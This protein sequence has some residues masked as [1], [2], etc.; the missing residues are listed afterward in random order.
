MTDYLGDPSRLAKQIAQRERY[1]ADLSGW[2]QRLSDAD[3]ANLTFMLQDHPTL[4]PD[5]A[6]ALGSSQMV[7]Y[8]NPMLNE[9]ADLDFRKQDSFDPMSPLR[10]AIRGAATVAESWWEHGAPSI[11]RTLTRT[12]QGENPITAWRLGNTSYLQEITKQASLGNP[13]DI[14]SGFFPQSTPTHKREGYLD[15]FKTAYE[16]TQDYNASMAT[17]NEAM[18]EKYGTVLTEDVHDIAEST[19]VNK[20]HDGQVYSVPFSPGRALAIQFARPDTLPFEIMSTAVDFNSRL[21]LDP[22]NPVFYEV[23]MWAINRR[24]LTADLDDL[25]TAEKARILEEE[26]GVA[27]VLDS[28]KR[29]GILASTDAQS[30]RIREVYDVADEPR[31][32]TMIDER[33]DDAYDRLTDAAKS[34]PDGVYSSVSVDDFDTLDDPQLVDAFGQIAGE[35]NPYDVGLTNQQMHDLVEEAGGRQAF[36]DYVFEHEYAHQVSQEDIMR[37]LDENNE[38]AIRSRIVSTQ[39]ERAEKWRALRERRNKIVSE[40][41]QKLGTDD[42]LDVKAIEDRIAATPEA[43]AFDEA[44]AAVEEAR[45]IAAEKIQPLAASLEQLA[46]QHAVSRLRTGQFRA[47]TIRKEIEEAAGLSHRW[48]KWLN[49]TQA[50]EYLD[51]PK[52]RYVFDWIAGESRY[53]QIN[54]RFPMLDARIKQELVNATGAEEAKEILKPHLG[55]AISR[56]PKIGSARI[57]ALTRGLV[58]KLE[59]FTQIKGQPKHRFHS[60][61]AAGLRTSV[62]RLGAESRPAYIATFNINDTLDGV[63]EWMKTIRSTDAEIQNAV[64]KIFHLYKD[65]SP[66]QIG[67]V[68]NYVVD[69]VYTAKLQKLGY[70]DDDIVKTLKQMGHDQDNNARYW[71]NYAM[72]PQDIVPFDDALRTIG[73]VGSNDIVYSLSAVQEAQFSQSYRVLP[74]L[75]DLRRSTSRARAIRE[76]TLQKLG[77]KPERLGLEAGYGLGALDKVHKVWRDLMLL[78]FGWPIRVVGEEIL[79]SH[80]YGYGHWFS[81]PVE[82]IAQFGNTEGMVSLIGDSLRDIARMDGLGAGGWRDPDAVYDMARA[83]WKPARV[84]QEGYESGLMSEIVQLHGSALGR[85]VAR[86]GIDDTFDWATGTPEGYALLTD[87]KGR[88]GKSSHMAKIDDEAILQAHLEQLHAMVTQ[89]SGGRWI[90]KTED[91]RWVDMWDEEVALLGGKTKRDLLEIAKEK[92]IVGRH[93]M[94]KDA[95]IDAIYRADGRENLDALVDARRQ[96]VVVEEGN[97][98]IRTM[99]GSGELDDTRLLSPEMKVSEIQDLEAR[100]VGIYDEAGAPLPEVVRTVSNAD[101]MMRTTAVDRMFELLMQVP[102][103]KLVRNPHFVTRYTEELARLYMTA[104][105]DARGY[106]VGMV[107]HNGMGRQWQR[108]LRKQLEQA[109]VRQVPGYDIPIEDYAGWGTWFEDNVLR[110]ADPMYRYELESMSYADEIAEARAGSQLEGIPIV[111]EVTGEIIDEG[112][113]HSDDIEPPPG[114]DDGLDDEWL[115]PPPGEDTIEYNRLSQSVEDWDP[116]AQHRGVGGFYDEQGIREIDDVGYLLEELNRLDTAA[117]E[118]AQLLR[119]Q[120]AMKDSLT[121]QELEQLWSE[122]DG[123]FGVW[124]NSKDWMLEPD[125]ISE[126]QYLD[127]EGHYQRVDV[128]MDRLSELGFPSPG[129]ASYQDFKYGRDLS[130]L[131]NPRVLIPRGERLKIHA[132][133]LD[134]LFDETLGGTNTYLRPSADYW[135]VSEGGGYGSAASKPVID[136]LR[137]E[138]LRRVASGETTVDEIQEVAG[139]ASTRWAEE[140][141]EHPVIPDEVEEARRFLAELDELEE[142]YGQVRNSVYRQA[143]TSQDQRRAAIANDHYE[144]F[145][146]E[147]IDYLTHR[148]RSRNEDDVI[149]HGLVGGEITDQHLRELNTMYGEWYQSALAEGDSLYSPW[150]STD[151]LTRI[152][153]F[154][155]STGGL[156]GELRG[157]TLA[158]R[159]IGSV[160]DDYLF[161]QSFQRVEG[162]TDVTDEFLA[163]VTKMREACKEDSMGICVLMSRMLEDKFDQLTYHHGSFSGAQHAWTELPDGTIIDATADQFGRPGIHVVR[164]GDADYQQYL[165]LSVTDERLMEMYPMEAHVGAGGS[166]LDVGYFPHRYGQFEDFLT[167]QETALLEEA[168]DE[169]QRVS[170][171]ELDDLDRRLNEI[172]ERAEAEGFDPFDD[173]DFESLI[174]PPYDAY[175]EWDPTLEA[176]QETLAREFGWTVEDFEW[177]EGGIKRLVTELKQR[178]IQRAEEANVPPTTAARMADRKGILQETAEQARRHHEQSE[179]ASNKYI[180]A[181]DEIEEIDRI[182]KHTAIEDTKALFYDLTTRAN[183]TDM[184]RYIFPFGD[185]FL[186]QVRIW[187]R[188]MTPMGDQTGQALKNWRRAQIGIT[189]ARKTGFFSE[190]E[191][192]NEVFNWPG[193]G[194]MG[195][196]FGA[197][198]TP[199]DFAMSAQ[200]RPDQLMM[201]NLTPR[202]MGIPGTHGMFVQLPAA[203]LQSTMDQVPQIRNLVNDFAFGDYTP[204]NNYSL[205]DVLSA[206]SPTYMRRFVSAVFGEE[207]KETYASTISSTIEALIFSQDEEFGDDPQRAAHTKNVAKDIGSGLAY[208]RILDGFI[209]PAQPRYEPQV[210]VGTAGL[211]DPFWTTSG[212]LSDEYRV[213]REM[214]TEMYGDEQGELEAINY[215]RK[216]FDINPLSMVG[217]TRQLGAYPVTEGAYNYLAQHREIIDDRTLSDSL[218]LWIPTPDDDPFYLPAYHQSKQDAKRETLTEDQAMSLRQQAKGFQAL[219][220]IEDVYEA[221]AAKIDTAYDG[222][223]RAEGWSISMNELRR[224]RNNQRNNVYTQYPPTRP[225]AGIEGLGERTSFETIVNSVVKVGDPTTVQHQLIKDLQPDMAVWATDFATIWNNMT[226]MS[227]NAD[228]TTHSGTW[229]LTAEDSIANYFRVMAGE[230]LNQLNRNMFIS[231][232]PERRQELENQVGWFMQYVIEPLFEGYAIE[233]ELWFTMEPTPPILDT[234]TTGT[235]LTANE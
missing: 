158:N 130:D 139:R 186:E 187:T 18:I 189:N 7:Q 217:H 184:A 53:D 215:M 73:Q 229:W 154:Y 41:A 112:I 182:A 69:E 24:V 174:H 16:T 223:H 132:M 75:R 26:Y 67:K 70:T 68:Y 206:I 116:Y 219:A 216:R 188:A 88:A 45:G 48:R 8:D 17:A 208:L 199:A 9:I 33:I 20:T 106:I 175:Y 10:G 1:L 162:T 86:Y 230:R 91:G 149:Q 72:V 127:L 201:M 59:D 212:A 193:F 66:A 138:L 78:R 62:R 74:N 152:K 22:L 168:L 119:N 195:G 207:S 87:I 205:G 83:N 137:T 14:G 52:N 38:S 61:I 46:E 235:E 173:P 94:N 6:S 77:L 122:Y 165:E 146:Q 190:D 28:S 43:K 225:N 97:E 155:S 124:D 128:V 123:R 118:Q 126:G 92:Q 224:W 60:R 113:R 204:T 80:A 85:R 214:F 31:R 12:G 196:M 99:I 142:K 50:S 34:D 129:S 200:I 49:P 117:A 203:F 180:Y 151:S 5:V 54:K 35:P 2:D 115:G 191:Y 95:L 163:E 131:R 56:K 40:E 145:S 213:A 47:A 134:E 111:D 194:L 102:T 101:E 181:Y 232:T 231:S 220:V 172:T 140:L 141:I 89:Q 211:E 103:T 156:E 90:R 37:L 177:G 160:Q 93:A 159:G 42:A 221:Q 32:I 164:K 98:K 55:I 107:H 148:V 65:P 15:E 51:N 183:Y 167:P 161:R 218:M 57:P 30:P 11:G 100:I 227:I 171:A 104:G 179:M 133:S 82:V 63:I 153:N 176:M 170:K 44:T 76:S 157:T 21:F 29:R 209:S 125:G 198:G 178:A 121:D 4:T 185:A 222:N 109:G 105:H 143:G 96:F 135:N 197:Q 58:P 226:Q 144:E 64:N 27:H 19:L 233:D 166:M 84:G 13:I 147:T 169:A 136:D 202:G 23:G 210:L 79:R 3:A 108:A 110:I 25:V 36:H 234:V 81:H 228:E 192:G 150:Y 114:W 39:R 120:K 71:L